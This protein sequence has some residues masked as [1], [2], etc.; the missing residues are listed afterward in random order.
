GFF[1]LAERLRQ[2]ELHGVDTG[3]PHMHRDVVRIMLL[4]ALEELERLVIVSAFKLGPRSN[5]KRIPVIGEYIK[6]FLNFLPGKPIVP[7]SQMQT[8][9]IQFGCDPGR[10]QLSRLYTSIASF[11]SFTD[12]EFRDSKIIIHRPIVGRIYSDRRQEVG[13]LFKILV[14]YIKSRLKKPSLDVIRVRLEN[15]VG[16]LFDLIEVSL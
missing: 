7:I 3:Q 10:P 15:I 5:V 4:Y 6:D 16:V 11:I 1:I 14:F 9:Q 8:G 12:P 13:R 2:F